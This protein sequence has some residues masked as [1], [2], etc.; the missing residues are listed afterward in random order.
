MGE[1]TVLCGDMP[2]RKN[3]EI[4]AVDELFGLSFILSVEQGVVGEDESAC[5]KAELYGEDMTFCEGVVISC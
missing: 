4:F 1:K 3:N 2:S 5:F